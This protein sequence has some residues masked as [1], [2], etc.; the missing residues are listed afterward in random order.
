MPNLK[1]PADITP[2]LVLVGLGIFP[3]DVKFLI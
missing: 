2:T 3:D 1:K